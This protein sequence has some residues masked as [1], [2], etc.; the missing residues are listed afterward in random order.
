MLRTTTVSNAGLVAPQYF[1]LRLSVTCDVV[2]YAER[3]Y[4]PLPAPT[5]ADELSQLS[6]LSFLS[7]PTEAVPPCAFTSFALTMPVEGF[8]RIAGSWPAGVFEVITT[9][10][11][12]DGLTTT[13]SSRNAGFPFRLISR[14]SEKTTSADVSGSPLAKCT[15]VFRLKMNVFAPF[16]ALYD[17]T[18]SGTA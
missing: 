7:A 6:A 17:E 18:R 14:F 3:T 9:R 13:P 1:V 8:A 10:Y 12:P 2:L 4:G 11:L 15:F 5:D 16:D